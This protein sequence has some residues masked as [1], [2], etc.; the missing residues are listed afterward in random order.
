MKA[1][2]GY[3]IVTIAAFFLATLVVTGVSRGQEVLDTE[4]ALQQLDDRVAGYVAL[5]T[6]AA[7][8]VPPIEV[9]SDLTRIQAQIDALA[10]A[11]RGARRAAQPGE[12]FSADVRLVVRLEIRD[13]L[14]AAG[15]AAEDLTGPPVL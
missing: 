10:G 5:R 3:R 7:A 11:I 4:H 6:R 2:T 14:A 15:I 8:S 13:A 9:L 12:L 1:R